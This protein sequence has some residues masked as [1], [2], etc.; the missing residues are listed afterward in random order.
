MDATLLL[1]QLT[2]LHCLTQETLETL[3]H[4][5][6]LFG[7]TEDGLTKGLDLVETAA[8]AVK[9]LQSL[10]I[11]T[12]TIRP[13]SNHGGIEFEDQTQK[14]TDTGLVALEYTDV[15]A[16]ESKVMVK[17]ELPEQGDANLPVE[18]GELCNHLDNEE[19]IDEGMLTGNAMLQLLQYVPH[20][21]VYEESMPWETEEGNQSVTSNTQNKSKRFRNIRDCPICSEKVGDMSKHL[22]RKHKLDGQQRKKY[23][24]AARAKVPIQ[25]QSSIMSGKM[26]RRRRS[27]CPI[28]EG[29]NYTSLSN[30]LLAVH[31]MGK[32]EIQTTIKANMKA[33]KLSRMKEVSQA[34]KSSQAKKDS[35]AK[36]CSQA[37]KDIQM[38]EDSRATEFSQAEKNNQGEKL[39]VKEVSQVKK[40]GQAMEY[41]YSQVQRVN[42]AKKDS[43]SLEDSQVETGSEAK[44]DSQAVED[45]QATEDSQVETGS[46]AK[47][48]SQAMEDSQVE[49]DIQAMEDSQ[50]ER[51]NKTIGDGK[52]D[53]REEERGETHLEKA[54]E[55]EEQQKEEIAEQEID[56]ENQGVTSGTKR[57]RIKTHKTGSKGFRNTR[58]CPI[59]SEKIE[60]MSKHLQRK[61]KLDGQE[62]KKYLLAARAKVPIQ[63]QS[64]IMSGKMR[65]RRRS[66]CPICE[67]K[68]YTSL[69]N[70]LLTVHGMGK[71]EIQT[72]IKDLKEKKGQCSAH[73]ELQVWE[74]SFL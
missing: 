12:T 56:D 68:N 27:D 47:K 62:R 51:D 25:R 46:Q 14:S 15:V 22:Q 35:H 2:S 70:H 13:E 64:S 20:N 24:L 42:Q 5:F 19:E 30:H 69:S 58:D 34:K 55:V 44:E 41:M 73:L 37:E 38:K 52:E 16:E 49:R 71:E 32:E 48:D 45:N 54:D 8:N 60:D 17:T 23:L 57:E 26:R 67:G 72:T 10:F 53:G 50:V 65:R 61:H 66:D 39:Q 28:C 11:V 33:Q 18:H 9:N 40:D 43:Q 29:K 59:C 36:K 6:K 4:Q 21:E 7:I 1:S 31:G 74:E 63:R 3:T